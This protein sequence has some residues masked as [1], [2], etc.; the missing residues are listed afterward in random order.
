MI[1]Q[2]EKKI[3][4]KI[5]QKI[6]LEPRTESISRI[7]IFILAVAIF[8]VSTHLL[9]LDIYRFIS[10]L[11]NF[12]RIIH[13]FQNFDASV[14]PLGIE[15]LFVS[16]ALAIAG[17]AIGTVI[18]FILAFSSASNTT[19]FK[20]FGIP[21]LSIVIKGL[22][23]FIRAIPNLV[24]ILMIVA[25]MGMGY[26]AGVVGLTLSS[27]GY[28]TKAFISTIEEQDS[29]V[30]EALRSNGANWFQIVFHGYLPQVATG[31]VAWLAIRMESNVSESIS[32]GIVGAGGIG[33]LISRSLRQGNH[34]A[35][36]AYIV[37]IFTF[38]YILEI[39]VAKLKGK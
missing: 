35:L 7:I 32:L 3:E 16:V 20:P 21:I 2:I 9:N 28:L 39:L 8:F 19:F 25:S 5:N 1:I 34:G 10:R 15:Q 30:A 36:A 14:I 33:M 26:I 29:H 22:V 23:S 12:D 31:F 27:V 37:V 13:M 38:L 24:L 4:K 11:S 6:Y 17:L 18:S